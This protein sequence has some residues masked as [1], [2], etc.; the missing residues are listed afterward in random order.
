MNQPLDGASSTPSRIASRPVAPC[1]HPM[2]SPG[3]PTD[4][5]RYRLTR[6]RASDGSRLDPVDAATLDPDDPSELA[7]PEP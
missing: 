4:R 2:P 1:V 3:G 6:R 7:E 5:M